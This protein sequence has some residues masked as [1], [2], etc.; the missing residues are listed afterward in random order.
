MATSDKVSEE[1]IQTPKI[2]TRRRLEE[3]LPPRSDVRVDSIRD[4]KLPPFWAPRP[5]LWFAQ[6][7]A[8]FASNRIT[9]DNAKFN[10]VI[11]CLDFAILEQIADVVEK[12]PLV[13]KYDELKRQLIQRFTDTPETSLTKV[14]TEL[15]LGDK[16]PSQFYR[17]IKSMAGDQ[18][19]E[20][21]VRAL[22][23]RRLP[24]RVR[25]IL[26]VSTDTKM[27]VLSEMADRIM[28]EFS[29]TS[30]VSSV[31]RNVEFTQI[32]KEEPAKKNVLDEILERLKKLEMG[33][34]RE[35]SRSNN[36]Q[37][38]RSRSRQY[39]NSDWCYYHRTFGNKA[40][41]CREPCSFVQSK[42]AEN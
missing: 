36:R 11:S 22:W 40:N 33:A 24:S 30:S 38:S 12:P 5:T 9:T 15:E 37:R 25:A 1:D 3:F 42:P 20:D 2:D 29:A 27:S 34:R 39:G 26:T 7:E 16:R 41:K 28:D 23:L 31:S 35:R 4:V 19:P 18:L 13:N 14:L 32:P 8:Q 10:A 21:A 17:E 6:V